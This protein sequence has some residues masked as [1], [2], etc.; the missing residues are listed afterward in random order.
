MDPLVE[1]II[2]ELIMGL[3][4][5]MILALIASGF[6]L[7]LGVMNIVNFAHGEFHMAG[8]YAGWMILLL[9]GPTAFGFW[10]TVVLAA[11][12]VGLMG[13]LVERSVLADTHGGDPFNPLLITFGLALVFQQAALVIFG[14]I[15]KFVASPIEASIPLFD[16]QLPVYRL[17]IMVVSALII[18]GLALFIKYTHWGVWIRAIVQNREMAACMGVPVPRVYQLVFSIGCGLAAASGVLV[19]P[20]FSVSASMGTDIIITAFIIVVIGGLGSLTGTIIAALLIGELETL[21]SLF[22]PGSQAQIFSFVVLMVFLLVRPQGIM[23]ER[24][25]M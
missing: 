13:W 14:T 6:T 4:N 3:T 19:A 15:G 23:G 8:A 24:G 25:L 2:V 5:G 7:I 22:V 21:G 18:F 1:R 11:V 9:I 16:L 12:G 20:I 10:V 17:V